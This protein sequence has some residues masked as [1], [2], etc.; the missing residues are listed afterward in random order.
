MSPMT[1]TLITP[2]RF[3]LLRRP[4]VTKRTGLSRSSLYARMKAGTFPKPVYPSPSTPA[5]VEAEVEAWI[6]ILISQR[7]ARQA[8][9][10]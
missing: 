10:A 1:A 6:A 4:E 2:Q 3:A 5:W 9:A 7:D 8:Q